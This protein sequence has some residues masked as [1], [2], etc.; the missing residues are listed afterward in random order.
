MLL[1]WKFMSSYVT[2]YLKS[3]FRTKVDQKNFDFD[4]I[5]YSIF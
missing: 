5:E 3:F 1:I 4:Q 2:I